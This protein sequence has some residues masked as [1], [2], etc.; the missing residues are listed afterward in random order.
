MQFQ[1]PPR[2]TGANDSKHL[3]QDELWLIRE[4]IVL[5]SRIF[6]MNRLSWCSTGLNDLN[7]LVGLA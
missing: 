4:R 5:L 3:R 6:P 1:I 7:H 2:A